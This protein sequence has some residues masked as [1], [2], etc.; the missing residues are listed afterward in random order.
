M[1]VCMCPAVCTYNTIFNTMNFL[2]S[3]RTKKKEE[4]RSH[5]LYLSVFQPL[6]LSLA[7]FISID[8]NFNDRREITLLNDGVK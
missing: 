5:L 1:S 8:H 4:R 6:P 7:I 2:S 3:Y